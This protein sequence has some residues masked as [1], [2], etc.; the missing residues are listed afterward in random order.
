MLKPIVCGSDPTPCLLTL[1]GLDHVTPVEGDKCLCRCV[2]VLCKEEI[3]LELLSECADS[4]TYLSTSSMCFR[5]SLEHSEYTTSSAMLSRLSLEAW[6]HF[7]NMRDLFENWAGGQ[8]VTSIIPSPVVPRPRSG[9][10]MKR[11]RDSLLLQKARKADLA[12]GRVELR[13]KNDQY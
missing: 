3:I 12:G 2:L 1:H 6:L 11:Q 7:R 4:L 13:T 5:G 10:W 8:E 9:R